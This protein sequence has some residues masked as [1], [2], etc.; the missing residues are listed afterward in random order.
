MLSK[1]LP[2]FSKK[3]SF[4]CYVTQCP[5]KRCISFAWGEQLLRFLKSGQ[6][7][8]TLDL[9]STR[10]QANVYALWLYKCTCSA[11][12]VIAKNLGRINLL[13]LF[14]LYEQQILD[15]VVLKQLFIPYT[16]RL[17]QQLMGRK[18]FYSLMPAL[19]SPVCF[20]I[21]NRQ[22]TEG[23]TDVCIWARGRGIVGSLKMDQISAT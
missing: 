23:G 1:M 13:Q 14:C 19:N 8:N 17:Q 16:Y 4:M 12:V 10:L 3:Q 2:Y 11:R 5:P 9:R 7:I 22:F 6:Y 18:G 20:S 21:H 15:Q